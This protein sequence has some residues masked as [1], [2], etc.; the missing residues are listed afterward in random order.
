MTRSETLT[1]TIIGKKASFLEVAIQPSAPGIGDMV[2][3]TATLREVET[4]A[5]IPG[6]TVNWYWFTDGERVGYGSMVDRGGGLY[7]RTLG[8]LTEGTHEFYAEFEGDAEYEGCEPAE[9]E[10]QGVV[11]VFEW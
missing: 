11:G 6:K 1:V 2:S 9:S 10:R 5:G 8:R 4:G 3:F 7:E